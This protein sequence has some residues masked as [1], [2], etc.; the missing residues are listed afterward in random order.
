MLT[1]FMLTFFML[2]NFVQPISIPPSNIVDGIIVLT[3]SDPNCLENEVHTFISPNECNSTAFGVSVTFSSFYSSV[4]MILEVFRGVQDC[5]TP[6]SIFS[7]VPNECTGPVPG[8]N[9]YY[10]QEQCVPNGTGWSLQYNC[11]RS[12][13]NQC[14][15]CTVDS[16]YYPIGQCVPEY[17]GN[18][19]YNASYILHE[20]SPCMVTDL[21]VW[22]V[23]KCKGPIIL[24][25]TL[26]SGV[27]YPWNVGGSI[28]SFIKFY[29][30]LL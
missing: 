14:V 21:L 8:V 13:S 5:S 10:T 18:S 1:F 16:G 19:I 23:G 22:P 30:R 11:H 12:S 17:Y 24:M 29:K 27:C 9:A 15:S 26:A 4:C 28:K 6:I 2:F 20:C 7:S 25:E 3:Y